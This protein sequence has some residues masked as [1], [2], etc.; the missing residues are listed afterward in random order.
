MH[1]GYLQNYLRLKG[2]KFQQE[3]YKFKSMQR[4][5]HKIVIKGALLR[6]VRSRPRNNNNN[7]IEN[8]CL[9]LSNIYQ[10]TINDPYCTFILV[11]IA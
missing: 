11:Y 3:I 6:A 5:R 8:L 4:I 9:K 7:I 2:A 1:Y 10:N